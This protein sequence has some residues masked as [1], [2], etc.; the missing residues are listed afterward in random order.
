MNCDNLNAWSIL[1]SVKYDRFLTVHS[2]LTSTWYLFEFVCQQSLSPLSA[3]MI[4]KPAA[5][6]S[7]IHYKV[8]FSLH[9]FFFV[10][11]LVYIC[12]S[13]HIF[14]TGRSMLRPVHQRTHPPPITQQNARRVISKNSSKCLAFIDSTWSSTNILKLLISWTK[15]RGKGGQMRLPY[16]NI[17]NSTHKLSL[18]A[19]FE[20]MS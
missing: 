17:G 14:L 15:G 7:I 3:T 16:G 18:V 4:L 13:L 12:K 1:N 19:F 9:I 8:C 20:L 11:L 5:K 10:I 6:L 2:I